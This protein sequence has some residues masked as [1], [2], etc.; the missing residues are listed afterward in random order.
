[1]TFGIVTKLGK[2]VE[3]GADAAKRQGAGAVVD[4]RDA[5]LCQGGLCNRRLTRGFVTGGIVMEGFV[6]RAE[7]W[8]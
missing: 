3:Y 8:P 4:D 7:S 5:E 1:M 2:A 6:M